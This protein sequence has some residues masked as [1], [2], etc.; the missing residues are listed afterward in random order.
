MKPPEVCLVPGVVTGGG[1]G[2][3]RP[4]NDHVRVL[5][6]VLQKIVGGRLAQPPVKSP[7]VDRTPEEALPALRVV[8][9]PGTAEDIPE[10]FQATHPVI[11]GSP[12][13][14]G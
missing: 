5:K 11:D 8:I 2:I 6:R 4:E 3:R 9:D 12:G 14:V 1:R 10:T 7:C 13:V